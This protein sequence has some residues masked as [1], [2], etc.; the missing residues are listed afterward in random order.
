MA[1]TSFVSLA[2]T[3]RQWALLAVLSA[4]LVTVLWWPRE[5]ET[6]GAAENPLP[7]APAPAVQP[8]AAAP[9]TEPTPPPRTSWPKISLEAALAHDP[10]TSIALRDAQAKAARPDTTPVPSKP[11]PDPPR[12]DL[13]K[14]GLTAILRDARGAMAAVGNRTLRVG[15]LVQGYR[16][17]AIEPDAVVLE[18]AGSE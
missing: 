2:V 16:V 1:E 4:T 11:Q 10:F 13:P 18:R 5:D 15:D 17:V 3:P 6:S 7:P 9:T 14:D 8:S 12:L